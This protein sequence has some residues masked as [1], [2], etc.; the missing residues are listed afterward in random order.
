MDL[1]KKEKYTLGLKNNA[2]YTQKLKITINQSQKADAVVNRGSLYVK[3]A[4]FLH[5]FWHFKHFY[6]L[7]VEEK[8]HFFLLHVHRHYHLIPSFWLFVLVFY[9]R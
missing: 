2:W 7:L 9:Q 1:K 5:I 4:F 3:V 6:P 8:Q